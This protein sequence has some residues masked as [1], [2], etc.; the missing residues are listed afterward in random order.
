MNLRRLLQ[1]KAAS[2]SPVENLFDISTL[3]GKSGITIDGNTFSGTAAKMNSAGDL[4]LTKTIAT[5]STVKISCTMYTDGNASTSGNGI[6][7]LLKHDDDSTVRA[8][9][10]V[11][12]D[13]EAKDFTATLTAEKDIVDVYLTYYNSG[14]NIWHVSGLKVIA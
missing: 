11:N 8:F 10:A 9:Y 2:G 1:I 12:A 4:A 6:G 13:T 3:E 7:V 14:Q 5:G